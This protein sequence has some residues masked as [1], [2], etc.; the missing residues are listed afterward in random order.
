MQVPLLGNKSMFKAYQSPT[1]FP[2]KRLCYSMT[3]VTLKSGIIGKVL[4]VKLL[5]R[6][7]HK[8]NFYEISEKWWLNSRKNITIFV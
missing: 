1:I 2:L 5:K 3:G 4:A 6:R 7:M 8:K